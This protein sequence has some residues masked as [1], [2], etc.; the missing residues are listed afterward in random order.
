MY[1]FLRFVVK[2]DQNTYMEY[3]SI[4]IL[5]AMLFLSLQIASLNCKSYIFYGGSLINL[6]R[7]YCFFLSNLLLLL[8]TRLQII[9]RMINT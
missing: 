7:I 1:I 2:L 8:Q 6:S 3:Y 9:W 5:L 4:G